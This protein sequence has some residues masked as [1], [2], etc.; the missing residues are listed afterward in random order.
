V[1]SAEQRQRDR[2]LMAQARRRATSARPEP[3]TA[4]GAGEH[5]ALGEQLAHDAAAAGAQGRAHGEL[6]DARG[7]ASQH[8][9][10]EVHAGDQQDAANR[11]PQ[12]DQRAA[13]LAADIVLERNRDHRCLVG[14]RRCR[15]ACC[16]STSSARAVCGIGSGLCKAHSR[17]EPANE[18]NDVAPVARWP[19][20]IERR[21]GVDLGAGREHRAK[22]KTL[23]QNADN[24][25]LLA[26]HV[27]CLADDVGVGIELAYS[28]TGRSAVP[29]GPL[30]CAR[31]PAVKTRPMAGC[32][33]SNLKEIGDHVDAG[34][35][36]RR[37]AVE[38][39]AQIAGA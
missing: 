38:A 37:A 34:G 8:Q 23:R 16:S 33:P 19:I 4:A 29:P 7:G 25:G 1:Q 18:G 35:G 22:V 31:R 12:H 6:L 39:E 10:G 15:V 2:S 32:T 5:Q 27:E 24:G 11:R 28:T 13:Q 3:K 9:V 21:D 20:E 17:L 14:R 26:V 36:N 30:H